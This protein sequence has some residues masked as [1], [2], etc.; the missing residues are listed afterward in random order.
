ML[1]AKSSA[2]EALQQFGLPR[3]LPRHRATFLNA[4]LEY[5]GNRRL[6]HRRH[7]LTA[8]G[9]QIHDELLVRTITAGRIGNLASDRSTSSVL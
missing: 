6:H 7:R 5:A 4:F 8:G 9:E 1:R 3:L 2:E